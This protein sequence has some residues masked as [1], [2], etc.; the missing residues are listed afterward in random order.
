[1][2]K[3]VITTL[4]ML[5]VCTHINAQRKRY[6]YPQTMAP[7]SRT[8]AIFS[9]P[10]N[11]YPYINRVQVNAKN[12]TRV[13]IILHKMEHL[14]A[15][16]NLDS[17]L[18]RVWELVLPLKDSLPIDLN[19]RLLDVNFSP[20]GQPKLRI[21]TF[22]PRGDSYVKTTDGLARLKIEQDTLHITGFITTENPPSR[23]RSMEVE[24]L[25]K[26][27]K[28]Y[29]V[30]QVPWHLI[31]LINN[32]SELPDITGTLN[33]YMENILASYV[34]LTGYNTGKKYNTPVNIVYEPLSDFSGMDKYVVYQ[35]R[36]KRYHFE[37]VPQFGIQSLR[38]GLG[39]NAGVGIGMSSIFM[40]QSGTSFFLVW[41]PYLFFEKNT[42]GEWTKNVNHFI[43]F[44]YRAVYPRTGKSVDVNIGNSLSF[45]YLVHREGNYFN[46]NTFKLGLPGMEFRNLLIHP[47]FIFNDFFKN[48]Y[49]SIRLL[50]QLY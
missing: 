12:K 11:S 34:S 41:E 46:K 1:M 40:Q 47:Q 22:P 4:V 31:I 30:I 33:P 14:E 8:E 2:K 18:N 6:A 36:K 17:I 39:V 42:A 49:P 19:N 26:T 7:V 23:F 27:A 24:G 32:L 29:S 48:S 25:P 44:Q 3:T 20:S 28:G 9:K 13:E 45:G 10:L 38:S 43:S 21:S 50:L 16:R 35:L 5:L 15:I 37:L